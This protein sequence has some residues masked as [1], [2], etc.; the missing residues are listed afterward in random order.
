MLEVV[1]AVLVVV[2]NMVIANWMLDREQKIGRL[3]E[4][5]GGLF[6]RKW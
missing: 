3:G 6:N 4:S 2:A 1:L 5:A